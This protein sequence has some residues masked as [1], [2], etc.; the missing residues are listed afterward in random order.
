MK[1]EV[2][3]D[4]V[5]GLEFAGNIDGHTITIDVDE[6]NGGTNKGVRPKPLM[7]LALAGCTGIDVVSILKK[8]RIDLDGLSI[9]VE[10]SIQDEF[11]KAFESMHVIYTFKGKNLDREKLEKAVTLSK[12]QYCGVSA[13]LKKAIELTYEIR[14]DEQLG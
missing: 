4:W 2:N 5:K 7:M 6:A 13:T 14:V 8:M 12:E 10:G 11:P 1:R 3:L 9:K